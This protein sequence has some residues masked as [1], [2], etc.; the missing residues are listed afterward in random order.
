MAFTSVV[1]NIVVALGPS[2]C[3]CEVDVWDA[4]Q[5][6]LEKI[7]AAMHVPFPELTKLQLDGLDSR[8]ET[9][10]PVIPDSFLG[11][12]LPRL[13]V[14]KLSGIPC[15]GLPKL[16]LSATHL[17]ELCLS[18]IPHSGYFSPEAMVALL[19][20]LSSLEKL[21]LR[22]QSPQSHPDLESRRPPPLKRSV[23]P[24]LT[25]FIFKG[26]MAYLEHRLTCFD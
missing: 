25:Q 17:V 1:D 23:I 13:R 7:L 15:P 6:Q 9:T 2:N 3:V 20:T 26:V 10:L 16:L 14:I 8:D 12:S 5:G 11:G 4:D 24:S 18:N 21:R 19:S 22:F